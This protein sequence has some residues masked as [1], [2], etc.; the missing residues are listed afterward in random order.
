MAID[1]DDI[2]QHLLAE[3]EDLF[4]E[5]QGLLSARAI[6]YRI[7]LKPGATSVAVRPYRYRYPS[8][9][10]MVHNMAHGCVLPIPA[11]AI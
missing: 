5:P 7:H 8:R 10:T 9:H 4:A 3:L 1:I 2:L 6:D 11:K